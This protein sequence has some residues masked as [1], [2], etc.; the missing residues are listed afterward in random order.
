MASRSAFLLRLDAL[1]VPKR[2]VLV[3]SACLLVAACLLLPLLLPGRSYAGRYV[4]DIMNFFDAAQR[5]VGGQVPNRDF[6]SPLGP[7][8]YLFPALGYAAG[9]SLGVMMPLATAAFTTVMLPAL[10]YVL[11]SRFALPAAIAAALYYLLLLIAPLNPGDSIEQSS[12]AMFYNRWCWVALSLLFLLALPA[13]DHR[14]FRLADAAAAAVLLSVLF[15]LKI[16][17]AAVAVVFVIFGLFLRRFRSVAA[18]SLAAT[19]AG[20]FLIEMFWSGTGAYLADIARAARSSGAVRQGPAGLVMSA[21]PNI[22][23]LAIYAALLLIAY[24]RGA[25]RLYLLASLY[26]AAAGLAL[27]NQNAQTTEVVTLVAAGLVATFAPSR[28]SS[29]SELLVP[30]LAPALLLAA[31]ALPA[32][33]AAALSVPF[34]FNEARLRSDA[35]PSRAEVDGLVTREGTLLDNG[36]DRAT[37]RRAY[38]D[39]GGSVDLLNRIRHTKL[40]QPLS[41][42]EYLWSVQDGVALLRDH[43][44][45]GGSVF[46]FDLA[47]PF[48]AL[49]G[50]P[51]PRGVDAWNHAGRTFSPAV[52]HP[53]S[54]L[55]ADVDVVM[56]PVAPFD[57]G[58]T[59]LLQRIYGPELRGRY[60]RVA[61]SNYWHAYA[62]RLPESPVAG[63]RENSAAF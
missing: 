10:A 23:P 21:I 27:L 30:G 56:V 41:Q 47:N 34:H 51:A 6:H 38:S 33:T 8:A 4:A 53:A 42:P 49:L 18:A 2:L 16:S 40:R 46:V 60:R 3:A 44:L 50:R 15:Y 55:F 61:V 43:P 29:K 45:L 26:M 24:L 59:R 37:L 57:L 54:E 14:R 7:I 58:T 39:G 32:A 25:N 11:G 19:A 36:L 1:S 63:A 62:R 31:L 28:A 52:H 13:P 12:Y 17:Y 9:G 20:V 35:N 5:I 22:G 48:N